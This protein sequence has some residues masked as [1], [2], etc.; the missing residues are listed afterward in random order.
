LIDDINVHGWKV[1]D[2][3]ITHNGLVTEYITSNL[4]SDTYLLVLDTEFNEYLRRAEWEKLYDYM[5]SK[6]F[7]GVMFLVKGKFE[8]VIAISVSKYMHYY[9]INRVVYATSRPLIRRK[10]K[11]Y[12]DG[13]FRIT[14]N[15]VETLVSKPVEA[16]V[17]TLWDYFEQYTSDTSEINNVNNHNWWDYEEPYPIRFPGDEDSK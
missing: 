6:G 7:Y 13:V 17:K 11:R 3:Y 5:V 12:R 4:L 14:Y 2:Y 15:G 8:D 1:G 16:K 10:H 9:N